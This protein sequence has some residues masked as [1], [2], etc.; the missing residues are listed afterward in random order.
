MGLVQE[1]RVVIV[2]FDGV[3]PLDAAGPHEV[4]AG[5]NAVLAASAPRSRRYSI[6]VVAP[7]T[8]AVRAESGLGLVAD[9]A[10][11][12]VEGRIDTLLVA[13]GDG[14][15]ALAEDASA[16][17]SIAS[18]AARSRR[19]ASVCSGA[20]V[21]AAAGLLAGRRATTHWARAGRLARLYP[22]VEVDPDPI[23]V[24]SGKVWTSAGV[25]AG[26]DLALAMVEDDHDAEVAQVVARW[27]VMFLRRPGGQTQFA[28]PVWSEAAEREPVRHVQHLVHTGPD[29]DLSV[30][31]LA[32]HACMSERNFVRVFTRE[33]GMPPAR[34]VEHVRVEH[35][36]RLLEQGQLGVD[37]VASASGFGSAETMRRAFQRRVG[38]APSAYR[39]R[40][41]LSK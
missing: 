16:I 4:F 15:Y 18:L 35:A 28:T 25:T 29:V 9:G 7:R 3:Q 26:I 17:R 14:V 5:A 1:R 19:V 8:G 22:D 40:F 36:R 31:A 23:F 32:R 24:R 6:E 2:V 20:F 21:L 11:A 13:G 37:A 30:A 27:L 12:D 39:D 33:V 38:V 41:V 10:L 34:Y